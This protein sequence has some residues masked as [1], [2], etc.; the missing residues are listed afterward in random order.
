M[1]PFIPAEETVHQLYVSEAGYSGTFSLP[2]TLLFHIVLFKFFF[3][4]IEKYAR[5]V[6]FNKTVQKKRKGE[7]DEN[8]HL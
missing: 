3:I 4:F 6:D 5:G 2:S 8:L 1:V 7:D